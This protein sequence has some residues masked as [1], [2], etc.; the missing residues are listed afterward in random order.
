MA[1]TSNK[2]GRQ[3]FL[4]RKEI[5]FLRGL[6]ENHMIGLS[7]NI[8]LNEGYLEYAKTE[9]DREVWEEAIAEDTKEQALCERLIGTDDR[10]NN[11]KLWYYIS[12]EE[13][14]NG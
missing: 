7:D 5:S 1:K 14:D 10:D 6:V 13:A 8:S 4:S 2:Y 9:S 12:A 3:I 11:G